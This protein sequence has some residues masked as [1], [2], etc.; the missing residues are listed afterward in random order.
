LKK[1]AA[2]TLIVDLSTRCSTKILQCPEK[3]SLGDMPDFKKG[4]QVG[5]SW[6]DWTKVKTTPFE[7]WD[8]QKMVLYWSIGPAPECQCSPDLS[9][10]LNV[11]NHSLV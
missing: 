3:S 5:G 11:P 2:S 1:G 9:K 7:I 4:D 10:K 8:W 6:K